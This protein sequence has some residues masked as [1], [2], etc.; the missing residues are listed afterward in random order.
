MIATSG[1]ASGSKD[2]ILQM[3]RMLMYSQIEFFVRKD[4]DDEGE[5]DIEI[6]DIHVFEM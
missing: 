4:E 1:P 6:F 3:K 2:I 5:Q